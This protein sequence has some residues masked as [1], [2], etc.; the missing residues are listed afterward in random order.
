MKT[1]IYLI[2]AF[3]AFASCQ[4]IGQVTAIN[5]QIEYNTETEY[6]DG[7][8][9]IA[10]GEATSIPQR[11][12]LAGVYTIIVSKDNIIEITQ[13]VNPIQNN[14]NYQGTEPTIWKIVNSASS[15]TEQFFS[16]SPTAVPSSFYNDLSEG[17]LVH[18]FSFKVTGP[19]NCDLSARIFDILIDN[20][21]PSNTGANYA[22]G[23]F[24]GSKSVYINNNMSTSSIYSTEITT[25]ICNGES[26]NG[27]TETG[28]YSIESTVDG[29]PFMTTLNLIVLPDNDPACTVGTKDIKA[30]K[31]SIFPNP[32][33][34]NVQISAE[35]DILGIAIFDVKGRLLKNKLCKIAQKEIRL[36]LNDD[37]DGLYIVGVKTKSGIIFNKLI[38]K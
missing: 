19:N 33:I 31:V 27:Y 16:V 20:V 26:S 11:V 12:Q 29:C 21:D 5:F 13:S 34:N 38:V 6:Y 18:L 2:F 22:N 3:I 14:Q 10:E 15:E 36:Q 28:T 25:T 9:F 30:N 37:M 24:I 4:L 7:Y 8:I 1:T 35:D 32:A 17:D 23:F